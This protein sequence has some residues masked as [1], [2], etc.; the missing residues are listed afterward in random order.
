MRDPE[1]HWRKFAPPGQEELFAITRA[2]YQGNSFGDRVAAS[3]ERQNDNERWID[4]QIIR[5]KR[6]RKSRMWNL[7]LAGLRKIH[8]QAVVAEIP[9]ARLLGKGGSMEPSQNYK[10][11]RTLGEWLGK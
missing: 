5:A 6:L 3:I 9:E 8:M 11:V 10:R 4:L 2:K 1:S 7:L